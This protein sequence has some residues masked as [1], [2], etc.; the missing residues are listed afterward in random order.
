MTAAAASLLPLRPTHTLCPPPPS[1]LSPTPSTHSA[2]PAAAAG[3]GRELGIVL[4]CQR[5]CGLGHHLRGRC[6]RQRFGAALLVDGRALQR[7]RR[8]P[9]PVSRP[10][11]VPLVCACLRSGRTLACGCQHSHWQRPLLRPPPPSLLLAAAPGSAARARCARWAPCPPACTTCPRWRRSTCRATGAE[12][13][14][15]SQGTVRAAELPAPPP[16]AAP[17]CWR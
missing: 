7:R 2:K 3:R 16:I 12:E 10:Q 13:C 5:L 4:R 6:Q 8:H 14:F 11:H 1:P 15:A 9:G 17:A